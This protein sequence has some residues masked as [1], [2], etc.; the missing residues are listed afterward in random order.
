MFCCFSADRFGFEEAPKSL[1]GFVSCTQQAFSSA[2]RALS[3][4]PALADITV[5]RLAGPH[6][7]VAVVTLNRVHAANAFSRSMAS[8]FVAV[9]DHFRDCR[10][11]RVV[12]INSGSDKIFCAGADLKERHTMQEHEVRV[13][14]LFFSF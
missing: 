9:V 12:V 3:S 7:G 2:R 4:L 14:A 11:T 10:D 6:A 8:E 1:I 5:E 13:E